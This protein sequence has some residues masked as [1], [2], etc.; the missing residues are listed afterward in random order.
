MGRLVVLL[1]SLFG[2]PVNAVAQ[3]AVTWEDLSALPAESEVRLVLRGGVPVDGHI[4]SVMP[5]AIELRSSQTLLLKVPEGVQSDRDRRVWRFPRELVLESSAL[6]VAYTPKAGATSFEIARV[7]AAIGVGTRVDVQSRTDQRCRGRI[8]RIDET[9]FGIDCRNKAL[10]QMAFGD[11][12]RIGTPGSNGA[13]NAVLIGAG[14]FGL[15]LLIGW[16]TAE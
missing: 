13:I 7:V 11:L 2:L 1:V 12:K 14:I 8:Q 10:R 16:Q 5:D 4:L 6:R 3:R 9:G 15:L